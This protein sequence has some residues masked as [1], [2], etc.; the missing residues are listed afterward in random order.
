MRI[1]TGPNGGASPTTI[2]CSTVTTTRSHRVRLLLIS[3]TKQLR[4]GGGLVSR[5]TGVHHV[6]SGGT[7]STGVRTLLILS[8]ALNRGNLQRTRIFTRTTGLD[9]IILAGL[10][11]ATG[12]NIT[13]TIIRR[14]KLPVHFVKTK[15]NVRSLQPFSDCRFIRTLL[16]N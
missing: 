7:P 13:L 5:L 2:I 9:N 15:R 3:A 4:G 1:V 6:I 11:N 14:L 12:N 8:T 16:D 10:S